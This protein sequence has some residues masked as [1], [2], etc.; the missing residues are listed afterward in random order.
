MR[1]ASSASGSF[2]YAQGQNHLFFELLGGELA[3]HHIR[4]ALEV[5]QNE[6]T[7]DGW[8]FTHE[9]YGLWYR[10]RIRPGALFRSTPKGGGM[11]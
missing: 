11:K 3:I 6:L 4:R 9:T 10:F 5:T 1:L 2:L 7:S 8:L